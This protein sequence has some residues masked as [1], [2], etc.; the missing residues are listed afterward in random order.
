MRVILAQGHANLFCI[1]PILTDDPRRESDI[2]VNAE[3]RCEFLPC[4]DTKQFHLRHWRSRTTTRLKMRAADFSSD[5][6]V[7]PPACGTTNAPVTQ[8]TRNWKVRIKRKMGARAA[9]GKKERERERERESERKRARGSDRATPAVSAH[10][11]WLVVGATKFSATGT[12]TRVARVRAEYP[13]Q[14]DYSGS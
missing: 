1:G 6:I 12:R 13:N 14:L 4:R 3:R 8:A 5:R 7:R 10:T 2:L 9:A 11:V